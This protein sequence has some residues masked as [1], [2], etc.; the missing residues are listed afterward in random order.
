MA[1]RST[2]KRSGAS[3]PKKPNTTI[4]ESPSPVSHHPEKWQLFIGLILAA[5]ALK[6]LG[7]IGWTALLWT[8]I[9]TSLVADRFRF[10]HH[11]RIAWLFIVFC[12]LYTSGIPG[13][14]A[15]AITTMALFIMVDV[16]F[17]SGLIGRLLRPTSS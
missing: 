16:I 3:G 4:A 1:K 17:A 8:V 7:T 10:G 5:I 11:R 14:I 2:K 6:A 13:S 15:L 12:G 9:I